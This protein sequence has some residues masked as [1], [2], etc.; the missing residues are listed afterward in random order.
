MIFSKADVLS[1]WEQVKANNRA[2]EACE[3]HLF[4][5]GPVVKLG[6]KY[7]CLACGGSMRLTDI[8]PYIQGYEAAGGSADDIWPGYR[9]PRS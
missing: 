7:P 6:D 5:G 4:A 1:L 3:R 8:G 2:L 9:K